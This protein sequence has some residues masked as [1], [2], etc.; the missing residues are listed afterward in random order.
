MT[1]QQQVEARALLLEK[2]IHAFM[3]GA[4]VALKHPEAVSEM[5]DSDMDVVNAE[6]VRQL[7]P[8]VG[9]LLK[10]LE[11]LGVTS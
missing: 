1:P 10:K 9:A 6:F 8:E 11:T 5:L 4:Y 3:T 7:S 2:L